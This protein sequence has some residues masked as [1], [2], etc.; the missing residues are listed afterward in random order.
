M[1]LKPITVK[2]GTWFQAYELAEDYPL[3]EGPPLWAM[4]DAMKKAGYYPD[5]PIVLYRNRD[6]E[7]QVLDG[8]RRQMSAKRI[9]LDPPFVEFIGT[10]LEALAFVEAKNQHRR[11]LGE[12]DR[13]NI[14]KKTTGRRALLAGMAATAESGKP[15]KCRN[16]DTTA[17]PPKTLAEAAKEHGISR[18][19]AAEG[20]LVVTKGTEEQKQAVIDGE[21][22]VSEVASEIREA[23]KANTNGTTKPPTP[24]RNG[25]L[26][27]DPKQFVDD[28]GTQVRHVTRLEKGHFDGRECDTIKEIRKKLAAYREAV[29]AAY[30][31]KTNRHL[32][33]K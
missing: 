25:Q 5:N 29:E 15:P 7:L 32:P 26:V 8:R 14:S 21:R 18:D 11:H 17:I 20:K 24:V 9:E 23:E 2:P 6:G 30:T 28:F 31:L 12:V 3:V 1:Q 16:S 33:E 19:S 13:E 27:F 10:D 4:A 22:S